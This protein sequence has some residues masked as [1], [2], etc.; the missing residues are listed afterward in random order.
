[1]N[2]QKSVSNWVVLIYIPKLTVLI[3]LTASSIVLILFYRNLRRQPEAG[4]IWYVKA[5]AAQRRSKEAAVN[6]AANDICCTGK[7]LIYF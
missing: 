1:M 6:N 5:E 4:I 7:A 2:F 3:A